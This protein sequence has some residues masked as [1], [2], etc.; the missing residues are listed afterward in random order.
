[1]S[2]LIDT[3]EYMKEVLNTL[4]PQALRYKLKESEDDLE[5]HLEKLVEKAA[6]KAISTV[7]AGTRNDA[8]Q[9]SELPQVSDLVEEMINLNTSILLT[10]PA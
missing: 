6:G 10:K 4:E 1:M 8:D 2:H 3:I 7:S 5:E 9:G